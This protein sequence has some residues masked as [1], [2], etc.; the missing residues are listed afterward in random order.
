MEKLIQRANESLS[1]LLN[2]YCFGDSKTSVD[3]IKF[4]GHTIEQIFCQTSISD[5]IQKLKLRI[6]FIEI[7]GLV[8][9]GSNKT[10]ILP[11]YCHLD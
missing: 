11:K 6:N 4:S 10:I 1:D 5:Q 2:P 7:E 8:D 3:K 9:T